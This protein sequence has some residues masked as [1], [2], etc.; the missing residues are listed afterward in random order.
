[1]PLQEALETFEPAEK[2]PTATRR[3]CALGS[4]TLAVVF[5]APPRPAGAVT[6]ETAPVTALL[7]D[8]AQLVSWLESH[9]ADVRAAAARVGQARADV[10]QSR[11]LPNPSLNAALNDVA[12]GASNP[13]GLGFGEVAI[14]G[15][16]L[17]ETLEI[18]K[19]GPR[20]RSAEL[21]L[22]AAGESYKAAFGEALALARAAMARLAYLRSRQSALDENLAEAR[23]ILGLERTRFD[24]GDISGND[25]DRLRLDTT[26]LE[27]DVAQNG[28]EYRAA[29]ETC[30]AL[31]FAPCDDRDAD[32]TAVESAAELPPPGHWEQEVTQRP[33]LRALEMEEQSA[34][35]DAILAARRRV[36]DPSVSLGYTRD[37]L[38]ISGDQPRTLSFG[39]SIPLPFFDRGQHDA[40]RADLRADEVHQGAATTLARARADAASLADR[41][42]TLE[43]ILGDLKGDA[44]GRSRSVLDSTVAAVNRGQLSMTD[45]LLAR[46]T[47]ADLT[48]KVMDLQ[49]SA[50]SARNELRRTLG[51]D[52]KAMPAKERTR[53]TQP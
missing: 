2:H 46:R 11:L 19:R 48:L 47:H 26:I 23:Q 39:V 28:S 31:L 17:S 8:P 21:R 36:P 35:Q 34:R 38:V 10:A 52:A 6:L 37:K 20:A 9:S 44:L 27:S 24:N 4:L 12:V 30:S 41:L 3:H 42:K 1:V 45:L 15:V 18:G 53:W 32:L 22:A 50:F 49:F 40:A 29:L 16:T 25:Y 33:D 7:E 43:R 13:P 5:L 14:Y 51:L